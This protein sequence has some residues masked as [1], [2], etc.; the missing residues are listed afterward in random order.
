[1]GGVLSTVTASVAEAP[2]ALPSVGVTVTC[3]TWSRPVRSAGTV[4]PLI[5]DCTAPSTDHEK[6]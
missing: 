4:S 1:M 6:L 3:Q 5:S 2:S